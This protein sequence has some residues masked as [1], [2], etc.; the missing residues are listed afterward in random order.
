[1]T[2]LLLCMQECNFVNVFMYLHVRVLFM[3]VCIYLFMVYM[4]KSYLCIRL[5]DANSVVLKGK[6][7]ELKTLS[8]LICHGN[9][10]QPP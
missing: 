5:H 6:T 3:I 2:I 8:D 1:M 9:Y 10:F 7:R 4:C